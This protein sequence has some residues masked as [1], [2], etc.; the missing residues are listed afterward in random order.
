MLTYSRLSPYS[1]DNRDLLYCVWEGKIFVK[2]KVFGCLLEAIAHIG[3][4]VSLAGKLQKV[5][6]L[7]YS[8][9]APSRS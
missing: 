1:A 4:S 2:V 7:K 5:V 6:S 3:C 8:T 9:T